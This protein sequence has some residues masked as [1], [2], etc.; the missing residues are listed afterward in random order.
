MRPNAQARGTSEAG[1]AACDGNLG[2]ASENS[3][4]GDCGTCHRPVAPEQDEERGSAVLLELRAS[5]PPVTPLWGMGRRSHPEDET[6][7]FMSRNKGQRPSS[8]SLSGAFRQPLA[9]AGKP[10]D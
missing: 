8:S 10:G 9:L 4:R 2:G 3:H 7:W 1:R 6:Q 5:Q